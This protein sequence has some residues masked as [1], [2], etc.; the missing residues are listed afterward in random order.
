M[1]FARK[2]FICIL[3]AIALAITLV[4]G[5]AEQSRFKELTTT[6]DQIAAE[7]DILLELPKKIRE[8]YKIDLAFER[9]KTT[10]LSE[11]VSEKTLD[12][13]NTKTLNQKRLDDLRASM[14]PCQNKLDDA[15]YELQVFVEK[16]KKWTFLLIDQ[17]KLI[18]S[19]KRQVKLLENKLV[20]FEE[21]M[22]RCMTEL[23]LAIAAVDKY[24]RGGLGFRLFGLN[25]KIKPVFG[26][27]VNEK[28]G[29]F[30]AGIGITF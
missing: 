15:L 11:S 26:Y 2:H 19:L 1:K 4:W 17:E 16:E 23:D 6:F 18:F 9:N 27:V 30:G 28:G 22:T 25:I 7:R 14:A 20:D 24:K 3:L 29:G 5:F 13:R 21:A 8:K 12:L 10:K